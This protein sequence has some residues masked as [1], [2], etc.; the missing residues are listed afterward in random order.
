MGNKLKQFR[1]NAGLT[2]AELAKATGVSQPSYQ[3]WETG[4]TPIPDAK[5]KKLAK[6]LKTNGDALMGRHP[7]IEAGFYDDSV[8]ANLNYYGEVAVHFNG[9]GV[10]LLL[11]ISDGAF[12]QLHRDMQRNLKF[13]TVQSLANQTVVIRTQAVSDLYFSSEAYDDYGP[14]H[15]NYVEHVDIQMPDPRDWEIVDALACD[16]VGLDEFSPEDIKRVTER[17]MITDEQYKDLVAGGKIKPADLENER[18]VN[19]EETDRIFSLAT[20]T[21]YQLSTGQKRSAHVFGEDLFNALYELTDFDG[22]IDDGMIRL[23]IEGWHRTAFINKD[24]FDYIMF[25]THRF[26]EGRTE[27][28]AKELEELA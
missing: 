12:S 15:G 27:V 26:I 19:K 21:T 9:G 3:R 20:Q 4:N 28:D 17:V 13:V 1:V 2:Q 14:E 25:P 24:A 23:S 18:A 11:S 5:L 8:D 22:E 6:V 7:P 10:P 16:G